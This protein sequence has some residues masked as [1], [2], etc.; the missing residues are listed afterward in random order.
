MTPLARPTNGTPGKYQGASLSALA[1]CWFTSS[2]FA[3][4]RLAA[5]C[6]GTARGSGS[7]SGTA[8]GS[9]FGALFFLLLFLLL[10]RELTHTNLGQAQGRI[11][12]RPA[13]GLAKA[14]D[15]LD[16]R[17]HAAVAGG[18]ALYF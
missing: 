1:A 15:P 10:H 6:L 8:C 18:P 7:S 3:A 12:F 13:I 11:A 17:Q 14:G 16:T 2:C 5:G 9:S 4:S